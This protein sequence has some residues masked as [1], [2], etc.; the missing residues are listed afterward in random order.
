[1][2]LKWNFN[3]VCDWDL[4]CF[5]VGGGGN[6]N[7]TTEIW[8]NVT[9]K[10]YPK[11]HIDHPPKYHHQTLSNVKCFRGIS[12]SFSPLPL[13]SAT[14]MI[15]LQ[16]FTLGCIPWDPQAQG[17]LGS[18]VFPPPF[19]TTALWYPSLPQPQ[20]TLMN[21][22]RG[23]RESLHWEGEL[24]EMVP[25]P[26]MEVLFCHWNGT[27][28]FQLIAEYRDHQTVAGDNNYVDCSSTVICLHMMPA[29]SS[30]RRFLLLQ[31]EKENTNTS[32]RRSVSFDILSSFP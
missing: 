6:D 1:M 24:A 29:T 30:Q 10:W 19:P 21:R 9:C 8:L 25:P 28:E 18:Q 16:L 26:L 2:L 31:K 12:S 15:L 32:Y 3:R 13:Y 22:I 14:A 17:S 11:W 20:R 4:G 23:Q 7:S 5:C 27:L